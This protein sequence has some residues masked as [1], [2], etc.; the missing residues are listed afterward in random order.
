M[1][2]K[3][4]PTSWHPPR[5]LLLSWLSL[6]A[7][8][9]ITVVLAYVPFGSANTVIALT[10][11]LVKGGI[12]AAVFMTLRSARPLTVAF[13]AA[14]FYWLSIMFWLTFADYVTRATFAQS[15]NGL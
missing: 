14:G 1:S 6:L 5:V 13:A 8:L 4:S 15:P 7:L 12:V 10:I 9:G 3:K 2:S 11:A